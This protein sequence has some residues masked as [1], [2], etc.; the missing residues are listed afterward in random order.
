MD[1]KNDDDNFLKTR[2]AALVA[3]LATFMGICS[4]KDD[5]I[6]HAMQQ[7]QAN[8][9]DHWAFYQARHIREEVADATIFQMKLAKT[10]REEAETVA[11]DEDIASYV[12]LAA[13]QKR[14]KEELKVLAQQDA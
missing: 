4:V 7:P 5:K 14:K 10:G 11:Y 9:V 8:K 13:D 6:N 12:I 1:E 3:I 2:V